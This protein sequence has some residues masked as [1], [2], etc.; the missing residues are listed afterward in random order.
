MNLRFLALARL[1]M[2]DL[3]DF[4]EARA[5]G[6]GSL[7]TDA[8]QARANR[9]PAQP[10]LGG[11]VV[12][13]PRGREIREVVVRPYSVI[14]TYEVTATEVVILAVTHGR[15]NRRPWRRRLP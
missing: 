10:R 13:P 6:L 3:A 2:F 7:V 9:L 4:F 11:R 14:I 8:V 5:A 15:S 12:R 1:D